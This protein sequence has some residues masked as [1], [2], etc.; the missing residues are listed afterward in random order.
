MR[1]DL[2]WKTDNYK[3]VGK[4]FDFAYANQLNKFSPI[5]GIVH[6]DSVDYE[7][8][9]TEGYG[10]LLLYDGSNLNKGQKKKGFKT[11]V[12]PQEYLIDIELGYKQVKVDKSGA[13]ARVG[14]KLGHSAGMTVYLHIIRTFANAF[15]AS[16]V[17]GDG[18]SWAATDHPVASKGSSGRTF[19]ADPD[20]GTYSNLITDALSVSAI[21]KMRT[22]ANGF[23]TPDGMPLL[24]EFDTLLVSP[25]LE[26]K[27]MK[28]CGENSKLYP[29]QVDNVN[30]YQK[31]LQYMVVGGGNDGFGKDQWALC[32]RKLMK[33]IFNLVYI[34]DPKVMRN[35]LDNPLIDAY[36]A[37][38]DFGI[39]W[40]DARQIIF[41]NPA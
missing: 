5:M 20:A 25:S 41:S 6:T 16:Q 14:K 36:V 22:M 7:I 12:V 21:T 11:I 8:E 17:G 31:E 38:C 37:Y 29:D 30:P 28:I 18:K 35:K 9:G 24:S 26:E 3:F 32:D 34:T 15:N 33:D 40:G 27:A 10:E 19:V 23:V 2:A 1:A 39:G 4:A 13:C